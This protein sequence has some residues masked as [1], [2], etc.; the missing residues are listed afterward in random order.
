[1]LNNKGD[2]K[3]ITTRS[4]VSYNGPQISS[5]PKETENEPEVTRKRDANQGGPKTSNRGVIGKRE[6]DPKKDGFK[7]EEDLKVLEEH[8]VDHQERD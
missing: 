4:G 5:P 6:R 2:V 3:A 1:M 7:V 8:L